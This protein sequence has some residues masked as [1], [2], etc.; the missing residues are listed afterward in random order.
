[1]AVLIVSVSLFDSVFGQFPPETKAHRTVGAYF[2]EMRTEQTG[3]RANGL[4]GYQFLDRYVRTL[5]SA[6]K[7]SVHTFPKAVLSYRNGVALESYLKRTDGEFWEI[8]EFRFLEG[9]P[10]TREDERN[11][12]FVAVIN[13]ATRKK[14]FGDQPAVGRF[15]DAD[16]QRFR[17]VGVVANVPSFRLTPFADIWAPLSTA[18]TDDYRRQF[19][20]A[21]MALVLAKDRAALKELQKEYQA[22]LARVE[23]PDPQNY[24]KVTGTLDS[25]LGTFCRILFGRD[26]GYTEARTGR[27]LAWLSAFAVLFMLLPTVNLVNINV[28]RILERASEIG[29]RKAFG[30]SSW[31]LVGQFVLENIVLTALG[32]L[33]GFALSLLCCDRSASRE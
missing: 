10:F 9:G 25:F 33:L 19:L 16:G 22:V 20:G 1:M 28:S 14:F 21:S 8:L 30:A 31:T 23:P 15:I 5:K 2:L 11:R 17:I 7:V 13:E 3:R 24:P 4:P 6:E 26:A 32:G 12:N 29:V 27:L 18:K